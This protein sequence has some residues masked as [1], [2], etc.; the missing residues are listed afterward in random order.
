MSEQ[1]ALL[2]RSAFEPAPVDRD[3]HPWGVQVNECGVFA[4]QQGAGWWARFSIYSPPDRIVA[5]QM[6]LGGGIWHVECFDREHA[7]ELAAYMVA[8]GGL[9]PKFV[10]V[11]RREVPNA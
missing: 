3:P 11:R 6:T 4:T 8:T 5:E 7:E 1:A 10:K 2:D 9:H